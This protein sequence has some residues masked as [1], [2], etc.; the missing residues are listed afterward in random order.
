MREGMSNFIEVEEHRGVDAQPRLVESGGFVAGG[1]L[2]GG[3][4]FGI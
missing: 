3:S 4:A 2:V 1:M